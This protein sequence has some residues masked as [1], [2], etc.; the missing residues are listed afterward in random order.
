MR[1]RYRRM[2]SS[3]QSVGCSPTPRVG[4]IGVAAGIASAAA[5]FS[6]YPLEAAFILAALLAAISLADDFHS[7]PMLVRLAAHFAAGVALAALY[8]PI[9]DAVIFVA[10][11]LA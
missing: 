6:T 3:P 8:L 2:I 9:A 5:F 11:V 1:R 7:L 10:T 4:G